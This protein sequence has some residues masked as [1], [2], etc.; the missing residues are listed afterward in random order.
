MAI[1]QGSVDSYWWD[2]RHQVPID[3]GKRLTVGLTAKFK[4]L[5]QDAVAA[6]VDRIND[7]DDSVE[8]AEIIEATLIGWKRVLEIELEDGS[9]PAFDDEP[10]RDWV[11]GIVGLQAAIVRAWMESISGG[12]RKN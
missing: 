8:D 2:V 6:F 9:E 5:D 4:R 3:S 11:L 12:K 10:Q 1:V 7:E